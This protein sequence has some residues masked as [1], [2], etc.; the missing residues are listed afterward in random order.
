M[1]ADRQMRQA[2]D[3][4]SRSLAACAMPGVTSRRCTASGAR[5]NKAATLGKPAIRKISR[6]CWRSDS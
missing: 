3:S 6:R 1:V 5:A 2:E 4:R